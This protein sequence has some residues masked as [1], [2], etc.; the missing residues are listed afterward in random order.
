MTKIIITLIAVLAAALASAQTTTTIETNSSGMQNFAVL[1]CQD[2]MFGFVQ[3]CEGG[4]WQAYAGATYSPNSWS[5]I[6]LGAGAETNGFRYGGWLWLGE[7]KVSA[8]HAFEGSG[9][10]PWHRT[11]VKYAVSDKVT[12]GATDRAFY[13]KGLRAEYKLGNSSKVTGEYFEGGSAT[14]SYSLTF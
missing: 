7:S 13:G 10:G 4:W 3:Y 14:L 9:S 8:L 11:I 2:N 5:Q 6:A 12:L 1:H